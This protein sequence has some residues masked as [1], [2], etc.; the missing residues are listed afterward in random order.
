MKLSTQ[1]YG[2]VYFAH[3]IDQFWVSS[4]II[5]DAGSPTHIKLYFFLFQFLLSILFLDVLMALL[6]MPLHVKQLFGSV[7]V[8][9]LN[10][11]LCQIQVFFHL[12]V[13]CSRSWSI[14]AFI[15]LHHLHDGII[16]TAQSIFVLLWTWIISVLLVLPTILVKDSFVDFQTC[17]LMD[18]NYGMIIYVF[19]IIFTLPAWILVPLFQKIFKIN[20]QFSIRRDLSADFL[21]KVDDFEDENSE[22]FT[23]SVDSL[24]I[25]RKPSKATLEFLKTDSNLPRTLFTFSI[26]NLICW[27]PFF[28]AL[29]SCIFWVLPFVFLYGVVWWG[30]AQSLVTPIM[31]YLLSDRVYFIIN[32][33]AKD[34]TFAS[35]HK[36]VRRFTF[37]ED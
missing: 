13:I 20:K 32:R 18:H 25:D 33:Q 27:S 9:V 14:A 34:A 31:I 21:D 6:V 10:G 12:F 19:V 29:I 22:D 35:L 15:M 26:M 11:L 7:S 3:S 24:E 23:E 17:T 1:N 5:R 36:R 4:V 28:I 30:F 37:N 8:S 2:L 16:P